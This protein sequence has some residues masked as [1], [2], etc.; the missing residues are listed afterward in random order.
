MPKELNTFQLNQLTRGPNV[1]YLRIFFASSVTSAMKGDLNGQLN[2]GGRVR[3]SI[4]A[5]RITIGRMLFFLIVGVIDC[6]FFFR[7]GAGVYADFPFIT[8]GQRDFFMS[9]KTQLKKQCSLGGPRSNDRVVWNNHSSLPRQSCHAEIQ[10]R[11]LV[12]EK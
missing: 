6:S 9:K 8:L 5:T 4:T 7:T 3:Q 2:S 1:L 11:L 10:N 12:T